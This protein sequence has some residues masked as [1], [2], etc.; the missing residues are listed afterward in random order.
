MSARLII[1]RTISAIDVSGI[2]RFALLDEVGVLGDEA[3]VH[4]E[5]DAVLGGDLP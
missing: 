2:A 4:H 5:E 3:G 1:S